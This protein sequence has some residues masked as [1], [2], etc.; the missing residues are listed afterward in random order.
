[1][2]AHIKYQSYRSCT[3]CPSKA[4]TPI[5]ERERENL[6]ANVQ[7]CAAV[8]NE[9][10][11][12]MVLTIFRGV[13]QRTVC[14]L[15]TRSNRR[16]HFVFVRASPQSAPDRT[17]AAARLKKTHGRRLSMPIGLEHD[18]REELKWN[19]YGIGNGTFALGLCSLKIARPSV[20]VTFP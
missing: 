6:T 20:I 3:Y 7:P 15:Q 18:V 8:K 5:F 13:D 19:L 2:T 9:T 1:M 4:S 16:D 11:L 17:F 14:R 12:N 10:K